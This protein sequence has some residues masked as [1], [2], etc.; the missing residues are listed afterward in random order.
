MEYLFLLARESHVHLNFGIFVSSAL[1]ACQLGRVYSK[2][3]SQYD[4]S[5][6]WVLLLTSLLADSSVVG[7]ST[8]FVSICIYV[9]CVGCWY[10]LLPIY[11]RFPG[12]LYGLRPYGLRGLVLVAIYTLGFVSLV[13]STFALTIVHFKIIYGLKL[14]GIVLV[15]W[16]FLYS[17]Y[18]L[19]ALV[20]PKTRS[21]EVSNI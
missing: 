20:K 14:C 3:L 5:I 17:G 7:I 18:K 19:L 13:L 11:G 1:V 2:T 8:V 10:F 6:F 16:A 15:I 21:A 9:L 12:F 4:T